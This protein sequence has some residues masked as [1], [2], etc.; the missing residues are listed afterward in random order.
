VGLYRQTEV[1]GLRGAGGEK[2]KN[3]P[4]AIIEKS[5]KYWIFKILNKYYVLISSIMI[6]FV[7]FFNYNAISQ[8][9]MMNYFK[10]FRNII[11]SG[12]DPTV[13]QFGAPAFPMWGYG[14]LLLITQNKFWLL[15][16]QESLALFSVYLF[17]KSVE[18]NKVLSDRL[19]FIIKI[20]LIFAVPWWAFHAVQW[21]GSV[22][23]SLVLIGFS[24]IFP[25][26]CGNKSSYWTLISSGLLFGLASNFRSDISLLP[27]GLG[28]IF[29]IYFKF[30]WLICTRILVWGTAAVVMFVPWMLY[31]KHATGHY[32]TT[33]TN[34]GLTAITGLGHLKD[35]RWGITIND[36]DPFVQSLIFNHFGSLRK[37]VEY[38]TDQFLKGEFIRL[39]KESPRDYSLACAERF[40]IIITHGLYPGE[41][42]RY[43][44]P[45][46][47][48]MDCY[49]TLRNDFNNSPIKTLINS[50]LSL[51]V[52]ILQGCSSFEGKILI[53][54]SFVIMPFTIVFAIKQRNI[55]MISIVSIIIYQCLVISLIANCDPRFTSQV[56]IYH[57]LN[58]VFGC[59]II[60]K[61]FHK[62]IFLP[63]EEKCR[64][65]NI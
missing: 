52:L 41:F 16:F 11:L 48:A 28:L 58:I 14:W 13:A 65:Q 50:P 34:G 29:L 54:L 18:K 56:Y 19:T 21:P 46:N 26:V 1:R 15:I 59:D 9:Y 61:K 20:I 40:K 4:A 33:S 62:K 12:F 42:F 17:L 5:K 45:N 47:H 55:I 53:F 39:V 25:L 51:M 10:D 7:L 49:L 6:G 57:L 30:R 63:V 8:Q 35:N 36:E 60:L 2:M 44:F 3:D 32:L 24:L 23:T 38:D 37:P 27:I 22:S 31:T 43:I 64:V